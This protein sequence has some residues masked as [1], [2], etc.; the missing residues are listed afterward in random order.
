[1]ANTARG[2]AWFV[3][4]LVVVVLAIIGAL[5]LLALRQGVLVVIGG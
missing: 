3:F 5:A 4:Q 2:I 1:M